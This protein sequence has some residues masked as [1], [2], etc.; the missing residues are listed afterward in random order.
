MILIT[1]FPI[2]KSIYY[3]IKTV[4]KAKNGGFHDTF[5][6]DHKSLVVYWSK[7][8]SSTLWHD[9]LLRILARIKNEDMYKV[10]LGELFM[11]VSGCFYILV[12]IPQE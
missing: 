11:T 6:A 3:E 9:V 5:S 2:K 8:Q 4:L 1:Q 12:D 7:T 10:W